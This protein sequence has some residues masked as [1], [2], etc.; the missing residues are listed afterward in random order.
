MLTTIK[1]YTTMDIVLDEMPQPKTNQKSLLPFLEEIESSSS[2][3]K[4]PSVV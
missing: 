2:L 3:K 4:R 1:A